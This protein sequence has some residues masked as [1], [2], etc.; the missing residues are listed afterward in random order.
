MSSHKEPERSSKEEVGG[1]MKRMNNKK[2]QCRPGQHASGGME[3]SSR[4]CAT[5][6]GELTQQ[7]DGNETM[8]EEGRESVL[9]QMF[10]NIGGYWEGIT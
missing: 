6:P 5:V 4:E 10:K 8:S 1:K 3:M 2:A 7:D 9:V